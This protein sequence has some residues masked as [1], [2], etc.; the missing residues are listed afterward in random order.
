MVVSQRSVAVVTSMPTASTWYITLLGRRDAALN[1]TDGLDYNWNGDDGTPSNPPLSPETESI[2][3]HRTDNAT[4]GPEGI[5]KSTSYG[6]SYHSYSPC[7]TS[8]ATRSGN[9]SCLYSIRFTG[10]WNSIVD[11][12]SSGIST[13]SARRIRLRNRV[14][15]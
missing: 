5:S 10:E 15:L 8:A 4:P 11:A 9:W 2:A 14:L 13:S 12:S 6:Y 1:P 7:E 3:E